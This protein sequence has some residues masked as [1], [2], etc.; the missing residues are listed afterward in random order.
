VSDG[1]HGSG[2]DDE[3]KHLH[4]SSHQAIVKYRQRS[5]ENCRPGRLIVSQSR[6]P[7]AILHVEVQKQFT[8][9]KRET[10]WMK[11]EEKERLVKVP[12]RIMGA[13]RRDQL[14]FV[15]RDVCLLIHTRKGNVAKSVGQ[16]D[17]TE[18]ARMPVLCPRSNGTVSTH[19]LTVLTVSGVKHVL[20]SSRSPLAPQVLKWLLEQVDAI[21]NEGSE[22]QKAAQLAA[23]AA[24]IS[25]PASQQQH[26]L[27]PAQHQQQSHHPQQHHQPPPVQASLERGVAAIAAKVEQ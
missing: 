6:R 26:L 16:F 19:I 7:I 3:N 2:D 1:Q 25:L 10:T 23:A 21:C 20:H 5:V 9:S 14:Y 24:T 8:V 22:E 15:A 4:S 17:D 13:T 27:Q 18:K 11:Q 12:V